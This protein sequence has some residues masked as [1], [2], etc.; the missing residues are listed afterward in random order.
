MKVG[1]VN[2]GKASTPL[3][4]RDVVNSDNGEKVQRTRYYAP[5]GTLVAFK[6][7][8]ENGIV[9][10]AREA[11]RKNQNFATPKHVTI[12][13]RGYKDYSPVVGKVFV[14]GDFYGDVII[15]KKAHHN[16]SLKAALEE[17]ISS[18][19]LKQKSKVKA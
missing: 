10:F 11:H 19:R 12:I 14:G 13:T 15:P 9:D 18:K 7:E 6:L 8:H 5:D 1:S 17:L 4:H 3:V 16:P 2:F